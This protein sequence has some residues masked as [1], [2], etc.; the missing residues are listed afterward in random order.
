MRAIKLTDGSIK[1]PSEVT[2]AAGW[3]TGERL[4]PIVEGRAVVLVATPKLADTKGIAAGKDDWYGRYRD[5]GA[6]R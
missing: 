5:R 1:L 2:R 6:G 3:T 4:V